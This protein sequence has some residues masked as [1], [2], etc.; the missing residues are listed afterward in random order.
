[1]G[2]E[3]F[4]RMRR[5]RGSGRGGGGRK[6]RCA[7]RAGGTTR[8][9][10]PLLPPELVALVVFYYSDP[11]IPFAFGGKEA[12]AIALD[13]PSLR[14]PSLP[15]IIYL[16]SWAHPIP[17]PRPLPAVPVPT[18]MLNM[19]EWGYRYPVV[20]TAAVRVGTR[21]GMLTTTAGRVGNEEGSR[22]RKTA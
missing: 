9:T 14:L 1:M 16:S 21:S 6:K 8:T 11:A 13:I 5:R 12:M 22:G 4:K 17:R 7:T 20:K 2:R 10:T 18:N 15:G 19:T 3:R